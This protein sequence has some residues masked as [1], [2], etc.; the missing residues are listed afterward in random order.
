MKGRQKGETKIK[1]NTNRK[2]IEGKAKEESKLEKIEPLKKGK[3]KLLRRRE[4]ERGVQMGE[5]GK[6]G[7]Q[8][9]VELSISRRYN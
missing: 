7:E 1:T 2:K 9:R 3:T 6:G 5:K 8:R 4:K